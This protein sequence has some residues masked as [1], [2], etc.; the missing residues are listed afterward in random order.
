MRETD[1]EALANMD[2]FNLRNIYFK[3]K[4]IDDC[5]FYK[6]IL[7]LSEDIVEIKLEIQESPNLNS[8]CLN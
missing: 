6:N 1:I 2:F 4:N 3:V 8:K 7:K 5:K